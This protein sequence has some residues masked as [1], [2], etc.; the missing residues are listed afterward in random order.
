M[1]QNIWDF[2]KNNVSG[3]ITVMTAVLAFV[4]A[5]LRLCVY[6]YWKG[7]FN[8]LNIDVGLMNLNFDKSIFA[9]VFSSII[10]VIVNFF[11]TWVCDI[12]ID[13]RKKENNIK[14]KGLKN[15]YHKMKFLG[16]EI[17]L[18]SIILLIVNFPLIMLLKSVTYSRDTIVDYGLILLIIYIMEMI[19]I[20]SRI[21]EKKQ[22]KMIK[23]TIEKDL[24][25][26]IIQ[27]LAGILIILSMLFYY[28]TQAIDKKE[29]IQLVENEEYMIT[30]C[31][32][33]HY[34]LHR[35]G[36]TDEKVTLFKNEQ[37]IISIEGCEISVKSVK[38]IVIEEE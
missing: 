18:S 33:E 3:I 14:F 20:Y 25:I 26:I 21:S 23:K 31:D 2:I 28:G 5:T 17:L 27:V 16:K 9:V 1:L 10:I 38:E 22:Q 36:Y 15:I 12:I 34:V 37:K 8:R 24:A 6:V 32:G 7:Y 35:V 30:Y 13:I 19:F 11:M 29:N 4:Y